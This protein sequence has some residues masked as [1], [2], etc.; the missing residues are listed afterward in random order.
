MDMSVAAAQRLLALVSARLVRKY[1]LT[2]NDRIEEDGTIVR[3]K[4]TEGAARTPATRI[5]SG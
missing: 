2:S 1:N 5:P 3:K 4:V